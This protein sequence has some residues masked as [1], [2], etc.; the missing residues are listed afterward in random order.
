MTYTY[1]CNLSRYH[2]D[3]SMSVEGFSNLFNV[4]NFVFKSR[5]IYMCIYCFIRKNNWTAVVLLT[6]ETICFLTVKYLKS[7]PID[8]CQE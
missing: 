7:V 8:K 2:F 3:P 5:Y 6:L 4:V 1:K